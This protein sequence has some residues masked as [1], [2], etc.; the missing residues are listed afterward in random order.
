MQEL[1]E[2]EGW[3]PMERRWALPSEGCLLDADP[4][5][6]SDSSFWGGI[7]AGSHAQGSTWKAEREGLMHSV[8]IMTV[9]NIIHHQAVGRGQGRSK[10]DQ[11]DTG[12]V[13]NR[14]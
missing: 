12:S 11:A 4:L 9:Y 5:S 8:N 13:E 2:A 14:G 7:T 10:G 3:H 6:A 1:R